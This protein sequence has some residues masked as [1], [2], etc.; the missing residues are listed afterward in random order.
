MRIQD[1][2]ANNIADMDT[3]VRELD[4]ELNDDKLYLLIQHVVTEWNGYLKDNCRQAIVEI[5]E[6]EKEVARLKNF[7]V[8]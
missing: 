5:A 7:I 6:L 2:F 1:Y 8:A 4:A 3:A